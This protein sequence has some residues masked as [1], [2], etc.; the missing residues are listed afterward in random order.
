MAKYF[1]F[2]FADSGDKTAVPDDVQPSGAVSYPQGF[3]VDY[4]RDLDVDPLAKAVPRAEFNQ[5][6]N[7][8]T[9]AIRFIQQNGVPEF[10]TSAD[11]GGAP[12]S[13]GL[14]AM[15]RWRA[16][17]G[18]PYRTYIS[19]VDS[20]TA[21]PATAANWQLLS[22]EFAD[23]SDTTSTNLR[24]SP[25]Y[26]AARL[27]AFTVSLTP[28]STTTAGVTRYATNSEAAAGTEP[29]AVVTAQ[30]LGFAASSNG[31][32][33]PD[34]ST[35]V[36]GK[37]EIATLQE[38]QAFSSATLAVTPFTLGGAIPQATTVTVGR[39]R[40]A[41]KAETDAKAVTDA[42]VTP[43]GLVDF[44]RQNT[45]VSFS[46]VYSAGGYDAPA[47]SS[48]KVKDITGSNPYGLLEVLRLQTALG[49]YK[50]DFGNDQRERLFLVAENALKVIPHA[51]NVNAIEYNGERVHTLSYDSVVPVL[52]NAVKTLT[53]ISTLALAAAVAAL[54][55]G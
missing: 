11:N 16:D 10:I 50:A 28:A 9:G 33:T 30:A 17:P 38:V 43:S 53:V 51:V 47:P 39:S 26:V 14:G 5:I 49:R 54:V 41:T 31:W 52:I 40:Y 3:G 18:D 48:I 34:A 8:A 21:T 44:T 13:Y 6:M 29:N 32:A 37:I 36:K 55:W 45:S 4:S 19:R 24:V 12:Y 23:N 7:D 25:A 15:V 46:L 42:A 20:N 27:A 2:P 22:F 35:T 1:R